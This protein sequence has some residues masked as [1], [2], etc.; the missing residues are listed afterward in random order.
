[1]IKNILLSGSLMFFTSITFAGLGDSVDSIDNDAKTLQGIKTSTTFQN[2]T[3]FQITSETLTVK[4]FVSLEGIVFAVTWKGIIPPDLSN[5]LGT[6]YGRYKARSRVE[7]N[8]LFVDEEKKGLKV[9][10]KRGHRVSDNDLVVQT[11]ARMRD[12][13]GQAYLR[14]KLPV[15]FNLDDIK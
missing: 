3:I 10:R 4:E 1:M 2:F 7:K 11:F 8:K 6:K 13:H 5:L 15:G 12:V 14:S 9:L